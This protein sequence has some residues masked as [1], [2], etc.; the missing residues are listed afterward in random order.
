MM[1]SPGPLPQAADP[2]L[3]RR[4]EPKGSAFLA[5]ILISTATAAKR[6]SSAPNAGKGREGRVQ[7]LSGRD[8]ELLFEWEGLDAGSH[9]G[10]DMEGWG[11]ADRGAASRSA[12][13][14]PLAVTVVWASWTVRNGGG[15][16]DR[17][18]RRS[19]VVRVR[20]RRAA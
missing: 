6:C 12:R 5:A 7:L 3:G 8:G 1:R 11:V 19:M 4:W 17:G 16:V 20:P 14:V 13:L 10:S 9:L 15:E 2:P 18:S